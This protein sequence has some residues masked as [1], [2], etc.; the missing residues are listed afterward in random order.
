MTIARLQ[1]VLLLLFLMAQ[2]MLAGGAH[3]DIAVIINLNNPI[4][5]LS[6]SEISDLYLGRRREFPNGI[7]ALPLERPRDSSLRGE[8]F[9][10][11]NGM[12][13]SRL[14]AYWAR[15][16]FSGNVQPPQVLR[17][18]SSLLHA[19]RE[20]IGAIAYV[21]LNSVDGSVRIIHVLER[22]TQ[23]ASIP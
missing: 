20:Q 22:P 11:L 6:P 12:T 13:L 21:P 19:V 18:D 17:D 8:F 7:S 5:V 10:L 4:E 2:P 3:S 1:K 14:N 15:L 16:Q 23:T 9:Q